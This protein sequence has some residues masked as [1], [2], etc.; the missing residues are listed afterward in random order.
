MNDGVEQQTVARSMGVTLFSKH[1]ALCR[2]LP[3][4]EAH[5]LD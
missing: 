1:G 3:F 5:D 2:L 4:F